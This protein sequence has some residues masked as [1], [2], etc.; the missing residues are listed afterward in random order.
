MDTTTAIIQFIGIVL[1]S[2]QVPNDPGLHAII[3]RIGHVHKQ[4]IEVLPKLDTQ[5]QQNQAALT[6]MVAPSGVENHFAAIIYRDADRVDKAGGWQYDGTLANG[7]RYVELDGDQVQFL[8]NGA[9]EDAQIPANLPRTGG[10]LSCNNDPQTLKSEYQPPYVGAAGVIDIPVGRLSTCETNTKTVTARL[11]T[12]LHLDTRG[13]LVIAAMKGT[14]TKTM[15]LKGD[16]V[17]FVANIPPYTLKYEVNYE[18]GQPHWLAYNNMLTE[19]C[20]EKPAVDSAM[21]EEPIVYCDRNSLGES[22]Y[23]A[24]KLPPL[25]F[26]MVDSEC[27]NT[28]WP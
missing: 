23:R 3:P 20:G 5:S 28:Q 6:T 7:W 15:V 21:L 24:R 9:N 18:I 12:R 14:T 27:S 4:Q 8:T 1:F 25:K 16:A 13:V 11:D 10:S 2:A 22:Y 26:Q 19:S 17:V